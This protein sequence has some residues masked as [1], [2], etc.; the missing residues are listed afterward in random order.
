MNLKPVLKAAQVTALPLII[1]TPGIIPKL[2]SVEKGNAFENF[3]LNLFNQRSGRF[4]PVSHDSKSATIFGKIAASTTYPDLKFLFSTRGNK[5]K[6]A[7][8][9]KWRQSFNGGKIHWAEPNQLKNY[10]HFQNHW[11][12]TL[13]VAIGIGGEPSIPNLLFVTPLSM[14]GE[15]THV[16]EEDLVLY[17]RDKRRGFFFDAKQLNL[18]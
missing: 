13:F 3:V 9:C 4:I 1:P 17:K 2:S 10:R 8:E 18:L 14:I 5:Y 16:G 15:K 7:V 11:N 12:I 6:F